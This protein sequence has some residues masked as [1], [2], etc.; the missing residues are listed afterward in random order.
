MWKG[1]AVADVRTMREAD[2]AAPGIAAAAAV[3]RRSVLLRL[4]GL[5]QI[6]KHTAGDPGTR[7]ALIDGV[8]ARDDR[9]SGVRVVPASAASS[10]PSGGARDHATHLA[11]MLVGQGPGLLG[12][13]PGATLLS[14]PAV[15]DPMLDGRLAPAQVGDALARAVDASLDAGAEVILFGVSLHG[16]GRE[17]FGPVIEA[18]ARAA[19]LGVRAV[20][21]TGNDSGLDSPVAAVTGVIPVAFADDQAT[22][23]P[24]NR[25][26]VSLA[27]DGL[28]APGT[29]IP[30]I[31]GAGN[32]VVGAGSSHAAAMVTGAYALLRAVVPG[33]SPRAIWDSIRHPRHGV[34]H[35]PTVLD[36]Q[37]SWLGLIAG[38][39]V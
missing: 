18:L 2:P 25:W 5:L 10:T 28:L 27:R 1:R 24:R 23:D 13:C 16:A 26:S 38:R 32:L 4:A 34:R 36:A 12:L 33:A 37:A 31:D 29:G 20:I 19:R 39:D 15:D 30:G 11:S 7:I 14:V 9:L 3:R 21:P 17:V 8:V 22:A 6:R 35:C